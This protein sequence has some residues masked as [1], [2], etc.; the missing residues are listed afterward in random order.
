MRIEWD[1]KLQGNSRMACF[2]YLVSE[3]GRQKDTEEA[4]WSENVA[5][6]AFVLSTLIIT[7]DFLNTFS[8]LVQL[9]G[10]GFRH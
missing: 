9:I 1:R 2:L 4:Q 3:Y 6:V 7:I 10:V 8:I 5:F